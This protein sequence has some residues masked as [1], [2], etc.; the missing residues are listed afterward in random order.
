MPATHSR[1][2]TRSLLAVSYRD[3]EVAASHPLRRVLGELLLAAR[4]ASERGAQR[5][6]AMQWRIALEHG[7]PRDVAEHRD[8]LDRFALSGGSV[9]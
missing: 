9:V 6:A 2:H 4:Q 7:R 3:D 8:W 1:H 5:E